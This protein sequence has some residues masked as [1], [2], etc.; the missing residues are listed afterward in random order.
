MHKIENKQQIEMEE[1]QAEF[2]E[3]S[4]TRRLVLYAI[5]ATR[6]ISRPWVVSCRI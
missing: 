5:D 1:A 3:T 2:A 4:A 6:S